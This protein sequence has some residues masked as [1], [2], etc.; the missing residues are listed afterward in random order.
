MT[1]HIVI[2]RAPKHPFSLRHIVVDRQIEQIRA[3]CAPPYP[4]RFSLFPM[5]QIIRIEEHIA[6][7]VQ[8]DHHDPVLVLIVPHN[9]R[10]A[11]HIC[12]VL[13]DRVLR[14]FFKVHPAICADCRGDFKVFSPAPARF[15]AR[16]CIEQKNRRYPVFSQPGSILQIYRTA[17]GIHAPCFIRKQRIR[18][19]LPVHKIRT[20][21]VHPMRIANAK[22]VRIQLSKTMI[23]TVQIK[24]TVRVIHKSMH[25]RNMRKGTRRF[26]VKRI[27]IFQRIR[28]L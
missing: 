7:I 20:Y 4:D 18:Q 10:I 9:L 14:V 22:T 5:Q 24:Q 2:R 21:H 26:P 16:R 19:L 13:H 15:T 6:V 1:D 25:R 3:F 28:N 27:R 23:L 12:D 11:V 8:K 17:A